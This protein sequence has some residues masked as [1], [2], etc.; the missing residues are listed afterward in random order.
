[1]EP[2]S[3]AADGSVTD[4]ATLTSKFELFSSSC[5][6][7]SKSLNVE[8]IDGLSV[9]GYYLV[10]VVASDAAGV[11]IRNDSNYGVP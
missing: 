4:K 5:T 10:E 6:W 2:G 9:G 11:G 1:M 8:Q 7:V 3:I